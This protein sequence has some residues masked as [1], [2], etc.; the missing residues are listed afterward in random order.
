MISYDNAESFGRPLSYPLACP[1]K[2]FSAAK[3]KFINDNGLKGFVMWDS[4]GDS[5]DILLDSV[6]GAMG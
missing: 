1:L 5:N 6:I 4:A 3:G 2:T